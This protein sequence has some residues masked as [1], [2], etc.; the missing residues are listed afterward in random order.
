MP[1]PRPLN[2][3]E[4]L[5]YAAACAL[6]D[7]I[8]DLEHRGLLTGEVR[9]SVAASLELFRTTRTADPQRAWHSDLTLVYEE[10]HGHQPDAP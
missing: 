6:L 3:S 7:L 2:E 8:Q 4:K 9:D 10:L 5:T 1:Q